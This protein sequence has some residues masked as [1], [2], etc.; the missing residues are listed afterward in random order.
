VNLPPGR[1]HVAYVVAILLLC[2]T[3]LFGVNRYG[4]AQRTFGVSGAVTES[5]IDRAEVGTPEE[6][7]ARWRASGAHGRK[8]LCFVGEWEKIDPERF[9][10]VPQ[11]RRYPLEFFNYGKALEKL[12]LDRT[13]FI[14]VA[15]VTGI[16]R[17]LGVVLPEPG[18]RLLAEQARS[19]KNARFLADSLSLT[20][21]GLPRTFMTLR[22]FRASAEPVLVYI[23]ASFF[24]DHTPQQLSTALVEAGVRTDSLILCRMAGDERV[25]GEERERLAVLARLLGMPVAER[26]ERELL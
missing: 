22:Q 5:G 16:V 6:A 20:Y 14:Y 15:T 9:F 17:D 12:R 19:A 24:R 23:G 8:V 13:T 11:E 25:S 18:Y 21:H 26:R 7:Y 3:A 4:L 10:E 2:G 1:R